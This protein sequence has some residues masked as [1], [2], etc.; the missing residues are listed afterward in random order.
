MKKLE[1]KLYIC[2]S[3]INLKP[4]RPSYVTDEAWENLSEV[5]AGYVKSG[6]IVVS[7][8]KVKDAIPEP[9]EEE[10]KPEE[11]KPEEK[12]PEEKKPEEKKPEEKKPEEKKP[13][14]KK[15]EEPIRL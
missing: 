11:K 3:G 13:E 14:E 10:K 15:P 5:F 9:V 12:K 1:S 4:G 8:T 7:D 2:G 6:S